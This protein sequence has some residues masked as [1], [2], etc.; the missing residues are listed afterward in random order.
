MIKAKVSYYEYREKGGVQVTLEQEFSYPENLTQFL[1][2]IRGPV[3]AP[4]QK[5]KKVTS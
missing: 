2:K 4:D 3:V 1:D 5:E